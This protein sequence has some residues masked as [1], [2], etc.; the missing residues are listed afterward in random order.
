MRG[1][2]RE[3]TAGNSRGPGWCEFAGTLGWLQAGRPT[4]TQRI[5]GVDAVAPSQRGGHQHHHIVDR[6]RPPRGPA[7]IKALLDEFGQAEL[8]GQGGRKD[9]PGI[10]HQT[11]IVEGDLYPVGVVA[12]QYLDTGVC[13]DR[14]EIGSYVYNDLA[15]MCYHVLS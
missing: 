11:R 6:I 8:P 15:P 10:G 4:G 13:S 3:Y 12:W 7:E 2:A 1:M 9:Q 14:D 5:G